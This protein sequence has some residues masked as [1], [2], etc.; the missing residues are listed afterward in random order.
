MRSPRHLHFPVRPS[1]SRYAAVATH[2]LI[3]RNAAA[4]SF[5]ATSVSLARK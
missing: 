2:G 3:L 5:A 4:S 1:Q